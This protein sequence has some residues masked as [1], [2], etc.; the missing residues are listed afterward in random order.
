M[1]NHTETKPYEDKP[2]ALGIILKAAAALFL[3]AGFVHVVIWA[4]FNALDSHKKKIDPRVSPLQPRQQIP[5]GPHLEAQKPAMQG[6]VNEPFDPKNL[7]TSRAQEKDLLDSY[8]WAD[9]KNGVVRIP[10][11]EAMKKVVAQE[12]QTQPSK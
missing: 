7:A 3:I 2:I 8:A 4:E 5:P 6:P 10:I 1:E 11:E 12:S 9:E